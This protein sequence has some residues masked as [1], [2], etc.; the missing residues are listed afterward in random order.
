MI[1][2]EILGSPKIF[3][4]LI[5]IQSP[6]Y[7]YIENCFPVMLFSLRDSLHLILNF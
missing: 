6:E 3:Y 1:N 5:L 2:I 7:S 4:G